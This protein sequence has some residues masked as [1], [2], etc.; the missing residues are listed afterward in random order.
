M[1]EYSD[2]YSFAAAAMRAP[3]ML[4]PPPAEVNVP[5]HVG[6]LHAA[7]EPTARLLAAGTTG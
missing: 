5:H 3:W 2:E 1:D 7:P 6:A 4:T